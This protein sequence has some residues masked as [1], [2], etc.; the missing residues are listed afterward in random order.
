MKN[1]IAEKELEGIVGQLTERGTIKV[2]DGKMNYELKE[3]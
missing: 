3:Q 1:G 2:I